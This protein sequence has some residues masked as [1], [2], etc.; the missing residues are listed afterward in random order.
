MGLRLHRE[1][2]ATIF[3]YLGILLT[4]FVIPLLVAFIVAIVFDEPRSACDFLLTMGISL[5]CGCLLTLL[6][7]GHGMLT[8]KLGMLLVGLTALTFMFIGALPLYLSG[9]YASFLDAVFEACSGLTT[10]GLTLTQDLDHLPVSTNAWRFLLELVGGQGILVIALSVG[11]YGTRMKATLASYSSRSRGDHIMPSVRQTAGTIWVISM[12]IVLIGTL[13]GFV[14]L[15]IAGQ[16]PGLS[17][18]QAFCMAIAACDT[19]GFTPY[20]TNL[21]FYHSY[22]FETLMMIL[23]FLGTLNFMIYVDIGRGDVSEIYRNIETRTYCIWTFIVFLICI[24]S[25]AASKTLAGLPALL[26]RGLFTIVSAATNT[27]FSVLYPSQLIT[28]VASG[29]LFAIL[30]AMANGGSSNSTS[31][32][33]KSLRLG[34]IARSL[35]QS[36]KKVLLPDSAVSKASYHHLHRRFLEPSL[37]SAAYTITILYILLYVIGTTFGIVL[38]YD[39]VPSMFEA[40]SAGSNSGLT[41]GLL[42]VTTPALLKIIY[43]CEMILGRFELL[44]I[45]AL[46]VA[47]VASAI[48]ERLVDRVY[49]VRS[50]RSHGHR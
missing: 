4:L 10:T 13:L 11:M 17:F 38:G 1:D 26:R 40:V 21:I 27:G 3:H 25:M 46:V 35:V 50:R 45:I 42:T 33:I 9:H 23:G 39:A 6:T 18:I 16:H 30:L 41:S 48:P 7:R 49:K 19:G 20:S 44:A 8:V 29:A 28:L 5:S 43:I 12:M 24:A 14:V 36:V 31:G 34:V 2:F 15:L 32:G 37:V 47:L 22:L